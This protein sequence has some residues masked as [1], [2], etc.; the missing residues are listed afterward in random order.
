MTEIKELQETFHSKLNDMKR[1][2]FFKV[3]T[4]ED[5]QQESL[6]SVWTGLLK[7]PN[8]TDGYLRTRIRWQIRGVFRNSASIDTLYRKRDDIDLIHSNLADVDGNLCLEYVVNCYQ[9]LDEQVI[10]KVDTEKFL[11]SLDYNEQDIVQY[12]LEGMRDREVIRELQVSY[13]RY[14]DL[15]GGLRRKIVE[16]FSE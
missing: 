10:D 12:K 7:D 3:G 8:A 1:F 6:L 16:H 2:I 13:E 4:N 15:K 9:P 5:L 14:Y 11:N